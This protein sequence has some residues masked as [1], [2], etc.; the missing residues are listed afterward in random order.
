[1]SVTHSRQRSSQSVTWHERMEQQPRERLREEVRALGRHPLPEASGREESS[2]RGCRSREGHVGVA[3]VD[4]GDSLVPLGRVLDP[5]EP[6]PV[7][8]LRVELALA[9]PRTSLD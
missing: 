1:M 6:V 9:E 8:E 2:T 4:G 5:L 3:P 7:D